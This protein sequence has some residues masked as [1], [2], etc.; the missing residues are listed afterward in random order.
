MGCYNTTPLKRSFIPETSPKE[1]Q[2]KDY[3][4]GSQYQAV[5]PPKALFDHPT[6]LY[7]ATKPDGSRFLKDSIS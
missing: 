7:L 4:S 6:P 3:T 1:R 2:E 5:Y